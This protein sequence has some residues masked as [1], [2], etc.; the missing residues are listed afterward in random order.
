L[1][2]H[3]P[4]L[5]FLIADQMRGSAMGFLGEEP[6]LTPALD[7][8]AAQSLVL[9]QAASNYPICSPYRGMWM[10]GMY[11]HS[12][13]VISNCTDETEP[14]GVE[15]QA[16]DRCWSDILH[17]RG[18]SLGYIGKWHLESPRPPYVNT[19]N[20]F[21]DEVRW[22]E[23]TPP[24]RRHGFDT[25][26]AY[27][28]YDY[29]LKP[30]YWSTH[31]RRE[32]FHY[33]DQW[34]PEH[35]TDL[36]SA[37][38]RNE[39][40]AYRQ[41]GVPFALVV[42]MNPPHMPYDQVPER[43]VQRYAQF[44]TEDLAQRPNIPP[45]GSRWGDYYRKNIRNYFAM[46]TGVDEAVGR[47]LQVIDEQGLAQDTIVVFTSDHGNCL[48]IH[49]C[50]S[51][52]VAYEE[53]LRVPYMIR[54]PGMIPHR[55]DDLLFSVPDLYPT[56][57][58]L[59]GCKGDIPERVEGVS[60]A[61]LFRGE[62]QERPSAHLYFNIPFRQPGLGERGLRSQR[63]TLICSKSSAGAT[64]PV[65]FDRQSDPYQLE[66]IAPGEP[67]LTGRLVVEMQGLLRDLHDPW[68]DAPTF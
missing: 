15:L 40:K 20:N 49:N 45:A 60:F 19:R 52:G 50:I 56:L 23:W 68:L 41:D 64:P 28:T 54:W 29:H 24:E 9:T 36:A 17:D 6:V 57:M 32:D 65:L 39:G 12:N 1:A 38:L 2:A 47:I 62:I 61:P 51:K 63:Y 30:M 35:E 44:T 5:V 67:E 42:S 58:D 34:G 55:T 3:N 33:V 48:G 7:R 59:M 13:R 25:W 18:Y 4:N 31:A 21:E 16:T 43:Y 37:Y 26:Y 8:F 22:N 46:I 11:P 27:N 53:S 66:N 10:T 14:Y